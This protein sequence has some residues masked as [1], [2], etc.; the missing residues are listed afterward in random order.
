MLQRARGFQFRDGSGPIVRSGFG[1]CRSERIRQAHALLVAR[2]PGNQRGQAQAGAFV[3]QRV[4]DAVVIVF[5]RLAVFQALIA[6]IDGVDG[7]ILVEAGKAC[8][9]LAGLIGGVL[10]FFL[11][12]VVLLHARGFAELVGEVFRSQFEGRALRRSGG[13]AET[14]HRQ[15]GGF[16]FVVAVV[17]GELRQVEHTVHVIPLI[18]RYRRAQRRINLGQDGLGGRR[19]GQFLPVDNPEYVINR[20]TI[21]RP[22]QQ[23]AAIEDFDP[24]AVL[25][26][27]LESDRRL[28]G[29]DL[30]VM[31]GD[32]A[33]QRSA[34]HVGQAPDRGIHVA[35][36]RQFVADEGKARVFDTVVEMQQHAVRT[37]IGKGFGLQLGNVRQGAVAQ[38]PRPVIIG[39]HLHPALVLADG[40]QW[41]VVAEILPVVVMVVVADARSEVGQVIAVRLRTIVRTERACKPVHEC[42]NPV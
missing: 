6:I 41:T 10:V 26:F 25:E 3:A 32:A 31:V 36:L 27:G 29:Q 17:A 30:H 22:R 4:D 20:F 5:I 42:R 28:V 16:V 38:Q 19:V 24:A 15:R 2:S 18:G 14:R 11:V 13:N 1:R 12:L 23:D 34:G 9:P 33:Q 40:R 37:E 21:A 7:F 35:F 8:A 39:A